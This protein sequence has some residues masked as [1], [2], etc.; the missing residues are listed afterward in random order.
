MIRAKFCH[1]LRGF[2]TQTVPGSMF[3]LDTES[4]IRID[5]DGRIHHTF[6]L[7]WCCHWFRGRA[8][9]KPRETW[10]FMEK[11]ADLW[12]FIDEN[13]EEKHTSI[14]FAHNLPFDLV[15]SG[16]FPALFGAGWELK[17]LYH[18]NG[19]T[20]LQAK[21]GKVKLLLLDTLNFYKGKLEDIGRVVGLPKGKVDFATVTWNDLKAY[22]R[23]D[24]E[25]ILRFIQG[26]VD[27]ILRHDLGNLSMTISGQAFRAY[28]HRFMSCPIYIHD[29]E[30]ATIIERLGYYGGRSEAFQV[31]ELTGGPFHQVDINSM[32]PYI[33][34]INAFPYR[35]RGI[36]SNPPLSAI[37]AG[38]KHEQCVAVCEVDTDEPVY[39]MR[40]RG[41]LLFPVGRFHT[42]LTTP[43]IQYALKHNHLVHVSKAT[44]YKRGVLFRSWVDEIYRLR[45]E[46]REDGNALYENML[47]LLMNSLYGKFGQRAES[48]EQVED[49][50]DMPEGE[51]EY[52]SHR[53][54]REGKVR[55]ICGTTW[56]LTDTGESM[57]SFPAI[58]AHVTAFARLY[59]WELMQAAGR[60]NVYYTDTDSLIVNSAGLLRLRP[61]MHK[62]RLG[63]LK[64][65]L[66]A[67]TL[68]IHGAKDY[69]HGDKVRTKGIRRTA[70]EV[71]PS[72]YAQEQWPSLAGVIN[73]AMAGDYVVTPVVKH[74][75][76]VYQK[77]VV[78]PTGS[79]LPF[80]LVAGVS[81]EDALPRFL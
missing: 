19:V 81:L 62:S 45:K 37:A 77:G 74:L 6:K 57:D 4:S 36:L 34:R 80:H 65:E 54:E 53:T 42:V 26:Y 22:C 8:K 72:V 28:R 39:P 79:V 68:I 33:M 55:Y 14:L 63:M 66:S 24:V 67:D 70:V 59:L 10:C 29:N 11:P 50:P 38:V 75:K 56:V 7:G 25:I 9:R 46:A 40:H 1:K 3:F 61:Y 76:R 43:E 21:R 41:R 69:R 64:L 78:S 44:I 73:E 16:G 35:L 60:E 52:Y 58:A 18:S 5:A 30:R 71:A 32:Y 31:G 47:K 13:V 27:F 49:C 12:D 15:L 20:I 51:F 23:N 48:W 17:M 2:D